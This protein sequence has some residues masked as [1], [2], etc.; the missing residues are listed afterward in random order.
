MKSLLLYNFAITI[1]INH[2]FA[3]FEVENDN[4]NE[5][6]NNGHIIEPIIRINNGN[7][8]DDISSAIIK[9][10]QYINNIN[11]DDKKD[12]M[13][14]V[15][16]LESNHNETGTEKS[17]SLSNNN[18]SDSEK[19]KSTFLLDKDSKENNGKKSSHGASNLVSHANKKSNTKI[20]N[21]FHP[22]SSKTNNLYSDL[23]NNISSIAKGYFS[24]FANNK[25]VQNVSRMFGKNK[26]EHSEGTPESKSTEYD[27]LNKQSAFNI[28]SNTGIYGHGS[29]NVY[30]NNLNLNAF[31]PEKNPINAVEIIP[32]QHDN[33]HFITTDNEMKYGT[34]FVTNTYI[35]H[36]DAFQ[37]ANSIN[38][39]AELKPEPETQEKPLKDIED[40]QNNSAKNVE[41]ISKVPHD[42][43]I[44]CYVINNDSGDEKRSKY[45]GEQ[46][47]KN[48][49]NLS[50]LYNIYS[51]LPKKE[52]IPSISKIT[53]P[54]E[55]VLDN[56]A[57]FVKS[58]R[59]KNDSHED[60]T[61]NIHE[62]D[63]D[64]KNSE[65]MIDTK[66]YKEDSSE[67]LSELKDKL[68]E[69]YKKTER[70]ENDME[71]DKNETIKSD[72]NIIM[73]LYDNEHQK[74]K[75]K[76][77]RSQVLFDNYN[78]KSYNLVEKNNL[79]KLLVDE[80]KSSKK[81]LVKRFKRQSLEKEERLCENENCESSEI[82]CDNLDD[83]DHTED[84][85]DTPVLIFGNKKMSDSSDINDEK[86]IGKSTISDSDYHK[87]I[88]SPGLLGTHSS[89]SK[90]SKRKNTYKNK[91]LGNKLRKKSKMKKNKD[92]TVYSNH[93]VDKENN[94]NEIPVLNNS[95]SATTSEKI[96][97][98]IL[99]A[100]KYMPPFLDTKIG[101][102]TICCVD[103]KEKIAEDLIKPNIL[104]VNNTNISDFQTK[105]S[106]YIKT[107]AIPI[108]NDAKTTSSRHKIQENFVKPDISN[109]SNTFKENKNFEPTDLLPE[110]NLIDIKK[111][112]TI[113]NN[114]DLK[115]KI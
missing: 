14:V 49:N 19:T 91:R 109:V 9:S 63:N 28:S 104:A 69:N 3:S 99:S 96:V 61:K 29:K 25:I 51:S 22:G 60:K 80:M 37:A 54:I 20:P 40:I 105:L 41:Y 24:L 100:T 34:K 8:Q 32:G 83:S 75:A 58:N 67:T 7:V 36:P 71:S 38:T 102:T 88:T 55:N 10:T 78:R 5:I 113:F 101:K 23:V 6:L 47:E 33:I 15:D 92:N 77:K 93:F 53:E 98:P 21:I 73:K 45:D 39:F 17:K 72:A 57:N 56:I 114:A 50:R 13:N 84:V 12:D 74:N 59:K 82:D 106:N 2:V 46:N 76:D 44:S 42:Q 81:K 62:S 43:K 110:T 48:S 4:V 16:N 52:S 27:D 108:S 68:R 79:G 31:S 103:I 111:P 64:D 94:Q 30:K 26:I 115:K 97:E 90:P 1:L 11:L 65:D 87:K 70:N 18:F 107:P 89:K 86:D 66:Y 95:S 112:A 35:K 85:A